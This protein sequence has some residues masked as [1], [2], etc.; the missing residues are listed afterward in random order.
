MAGSVDKHEIVRLLRERVSADLAVMSAAQKT[1]VDG[2][3]HEENRPESD[4]DTRA[5][6][7][8]YLARGQAQRV[9]ELQD[10]INKLKALELRAFGKESSIGLGALVTVDDGTDAVH[11]FIA[12][13]GGGL[14]LTLEQLEVRV[15]TPQAPIAQALLGKREGDDL[16]L[17]TPQGVSEC[18]IVSVS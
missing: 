1:V 18:S 7:Q 14:R 17:R 13:A 8:S 16:D 6:E 12:P 10:A 9:V 2:A 11:Y 5:L 3:T 4:K 15:V